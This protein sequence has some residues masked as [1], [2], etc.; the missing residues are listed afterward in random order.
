MALNSFGALFARV[1]FEL[2]A[3][4]FLHFLFQSNVSNRINISFILLIYHLPMVVMPSRGMHA[5]LHS[6]RCDE[7]VR[8]A[9]KTIAL[10]FLSTW[11]FFRLI[12]LAFGDEDEEGS[13]PP[14]IIVENCS[15]GRIWGFDLMERTLEGL[16][17]HAFKGE[18][19][20]L[21]GAT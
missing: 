12:V 17:R 14:V 9:V 20:R 16:R 18:T 6:I 5:P 13:R 4:C 8:R 15:S 1:P 21:S 2:T 10:R 7:N 3:Y 11:Y 19:V